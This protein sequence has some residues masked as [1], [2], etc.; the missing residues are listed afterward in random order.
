MS[1]S[2]DLLF[3]IFPIIF[4]IFVILFF[5]ILFVQ[6]AQSVREW[7]HN[8]HSPRLSVAARVVGKR[9]NVTHNHN[10]STT[11]Y[12]VTFEVESGDRMELHVKGGE[13]G[14]LIEGDTGTLTFQGTRYLLF[15]AKSSCVF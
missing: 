13:Y 2:F 5:G 1:D 7:N 4:A 9:Q 3:N 15:T 11:N 6:V 14:L 10:S 12:Y 8:N